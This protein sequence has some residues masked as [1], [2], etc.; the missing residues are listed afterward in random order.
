M[1]QVP[2]SS[3]SPRSSNSAQ[4]HCSVGSDASGQDSP[5]RLL[6]AGNTNGFMPAA[7]DDAADT[8][9]AAAA[10]GTAADID[11]STIQA[12]ALPSRCLLLLNLPAEMQDAE[13]RQLL[14]VGA[15]AHSIARYRRCRCL[16]GS[17]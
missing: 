15:L 16:L 13:V 5:H 11:P 10:A 7:V 1:G 4:S 3:A 9:G 12:S 6:A 17:G 14:Q 8:A 2:G